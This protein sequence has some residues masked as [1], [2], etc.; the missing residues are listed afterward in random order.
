MKVMKI[1]SIFSTDFLSFRFHIFFI[2]YKK[3]GRIIFIIKQ[4]AREWCLPAER[5]TVCFGRL[6]KWS[7]PNYKSTLAS[8]RSEKVGEYSLPKKTWKKAISVWYFLYIS[9]LLCGGKRLLLEGKLPMGGS[10]L[11]GMWPSLHPE[12]PCLPLKGSNERNWQQKTNKNYLALWKTRNWSWKSA[13]E[14]HF[15]T[16]FFLSIS[17]Q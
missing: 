1:T 6:K 15:R 17:L 3:T 8:Q 10:Y 12:R 7:F 13:V 9:L 2:Y 4:Q 11:K 14:N 5:K 16:Y